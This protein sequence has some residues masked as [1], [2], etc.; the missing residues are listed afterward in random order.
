MITYD[1]SPLPTV[2]NTR[3][4]SE[5]MCLPWLCCPGALQRRWC[6]QARH[7]ARAWLWLKGCGAADPAERDVAVP[8]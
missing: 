1:T 8:V 5:G 7:P 2:A 4:H 3:F 6:A